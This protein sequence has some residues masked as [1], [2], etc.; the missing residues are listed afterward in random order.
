MADESLDWF[1]TV[2]STVMIVSST[3]EL[4]L[5]ERMYDHEN[6]REIN[7]Q[8]LKLQKFLTQD[9]LKFLN[10]ECF[11]KTSFFEDKIC[12]QL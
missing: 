8:D 12:R 4:F 3:N 11:T 2:S 7:E 1:A 6:I 5:F 10:E 9:D